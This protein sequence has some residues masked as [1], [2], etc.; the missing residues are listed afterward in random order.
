M[1]TEPARKELR[2]VMVPQQLE[3][4]KREMY[5]CVGLGGGSAGWPSSDGRNDGSR[6]RPPL[7]VLC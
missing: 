6:T 2:G 5:P 7:R 1:A 3:P 4:V